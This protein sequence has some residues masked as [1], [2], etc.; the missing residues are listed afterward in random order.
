MNFDFSNYTYAGLIGVFSAIIGMCYPLMLQAIDGIDEKYHV[1]RFVELFKEEKVY[2]RFNV[3]LLLSISFAVID[4]FALS[5][6][7]NILWMQVCV[8]VC[9]TLV[10]L[11]LLMCIID[12]YRMILIYKDSHQFI[13]H[14][15]QKTDFYV[16]ELID[17]AKYAAQN[18]D[19]N[20]YNKCIQHVFDFLSKEKI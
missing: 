4:P 9:H 7:N 11:L 6:M 5:L 20:L 1:V 13:E 3:L 16:L 8:L 17:L 14:L 2:A 12:L 19:I 18:E 10:I 15:L